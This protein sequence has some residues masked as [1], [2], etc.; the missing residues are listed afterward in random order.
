MRRWQ[1]RGQQW[2]VCFPGP[3]SFNG[4][5]STWGRLKE[6]TNNEISMHT[7]EE[8]DR[9][10]FFDSARFLWHFQGPCLSSPYLE[11]P[12]SSS[13]EDEIPQEAYER[14]RAYLSTIQ[15]GESETPIINLAAPAGEFGRNFLFSFWCKR[16][17]PQGRIEESRLEIQSTSMG[18][19]VTSM[20]CS[21]FPPQ[22]L[23][24]V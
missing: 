11:T 17:N 1:A 19:L 16:T 22:V 21:H 4:N 9:S 10:S 6:E 5:I 18:V 3:L 12:P 20:I 13:S 23:S 2:R 14:V 8:L 7:S 15:Y 24:R